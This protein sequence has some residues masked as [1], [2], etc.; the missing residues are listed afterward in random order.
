[1]QSYTR[2]QLKQD[3]FVEATN[4]AVHWTVE[5]RNTI[6]V[7]VVIAAIALAGYIGWA[8]YLSK[9]DEQA[10]VA[11]GKAVQTYSTPLRQQADANDPDAAKTF[12]TAKDRASAAFNEFQ[13][14]AEKYP[15]ARNGHYAR[16]LAGIAAIEKDDNAAAEDQLKKAA[17]TDQ[18]TTAMAKFALAGLYASQQKTDQAAKL[19]REVADADRAVASK[20]QAL[21]A[22]AE[23]QETKNPGEAVKVYEEI[24]KAEQ[25]RTKE[26]LKQNPTAKVPTNPDEMKSPLQQQAEAKIAQLK[27]SAGKK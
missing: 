16:Y 7:V 13:Q 14:V 23:M 2:R 17:Q 9:Q 21:V 27:A 4:E 22:L 15:H 11:L 1:V 3:K 25:E 19:Y 18:D 20:P 10:S 26:Y 12:A 8:F 24:I 6:I 5:H